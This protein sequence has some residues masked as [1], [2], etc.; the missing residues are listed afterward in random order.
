MMMYRDFA[1]RKARGLGVVGYV[2]NKDDGT[3]SLI[4]EGE[5]DKLLLFIGELRKGSLLSRVD[6]AD[7][8]WK[9]PTGEFKSFS[10]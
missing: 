9:E 7:V 5:E 10:I 8:E 2:E 3:V 4:G 1:F 6:R